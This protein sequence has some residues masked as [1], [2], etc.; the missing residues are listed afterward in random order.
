VRGAALLGVGVACGGV[1][2]VV[3]TAQEPAPVACPDKPAAYSGTDDVLNE[4]RQLR[5]DQAD[6]CAA[7]LERADAIDGRL[8]GTVDVQEVNPAGATDVAPVT[9][10]I[11]ASRDW[12]HGDAWW[13]I[14]LLIGLAF[15]YWL[16]RAV[17]PRG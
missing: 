1:V 15:A 7:Q 12:A 17:S 9:A 2:P 10:A 16:Y 5:R 14:G 13:T 8:A 4:L 11:E 3:A 6:A